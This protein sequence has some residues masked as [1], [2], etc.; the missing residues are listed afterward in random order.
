MPARQFWLCDCKVCTRVPRDAGQP[1]SV[2]LSSVTPERK[3]EDRDAERD[4]EPKAYGRDEQQCIRTCLLRRRRLPCHVHCRT[5]PWSVSLQS[6]RPCGAC[7][8]RD[9]DGEGEGRHQ[10]RHAPKVQRT[11]TKAS[12]RHALCA[13][14]R[15]ALLQHVMG[16]THQH[17]ARFGA[18]PLLSLPLFS[19]SC[20]FFQLLTFPL[21][22]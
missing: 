12:E 15:H 14:M 4:A 21:T 13:A 9:E 2:A 19:V 22:E 3:Q 18:T 6:A 11:E 10:R 5:G 16:N 8:E 1:I 20:L 17:R 7:G